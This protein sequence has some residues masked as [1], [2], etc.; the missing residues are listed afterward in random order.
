MVLPTTRTKEITIKN[1]VVNVCFLVKNFTPRKR[2]FRLSTVPVDNFRENKGFRWK[3][4]TNTGGLMVCLYFRQNFKHCKNRYL[5][6]FWGVCSFTSVESEDMATGMHEVGRNAPVLVDNF[7]Y[8]EEK[9]SDEKAGYVV[10][11]GASL[12][13]FFDPLP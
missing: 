8:H 7:G 1:R 12:I 11:V 10:I 4:S 9:K 3:I 6:D 5:A 2:P 13:C